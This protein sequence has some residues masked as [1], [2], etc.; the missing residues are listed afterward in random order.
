MDLIKLDKDGQHHFAVFDV[1]RSEQTALILSTDQSLSSA[2]DALLIFTVK[3][4]L[5][6]S[7][8]LTCY[9]DQTL[10][11]VTSDQD[12]HCLGIISSNLGPTDC[13]LC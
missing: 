13:K 8:I 5:N 3:S 9:G 11:Y 10:L 2:S 4:T 6:Y 7:L 1:S 12:L